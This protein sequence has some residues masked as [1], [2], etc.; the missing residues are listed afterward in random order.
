MPKCD[1]ISATKSTETLKERSVGSREPSEVGRGPEP[2]DEPDVRTVSTVSQAAS[3]ASLHR[4]AGERST[5]SKG[6]SD[7]GDRIK[8][9]QGASDAVASD[10]GDSAA[11]T[12]EPNPDS[13][14]QRIY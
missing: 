11:N 6:A 7:A 12:C 13:S 3:D 14:R 2:G 10:A 9:S 1:V 8:M 5:V 4:D